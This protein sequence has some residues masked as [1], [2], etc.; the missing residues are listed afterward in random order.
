MG[1]VTGLP[2][3]AALRLGVLGVGRS[4]E[5]LTRLLELKAVKLDCLEGSTNRGR[6]RMHT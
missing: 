6:N 2:G 4:D 5:G 3:I 1:F